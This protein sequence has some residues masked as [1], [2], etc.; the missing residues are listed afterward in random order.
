M[1][2]SSLSI[3]S[4]TASRWRCCTGFETPESW[5]PTPQFF[6]PALFLSFFTC[7]ICSWVE[8][9][10]NDYQTKNTEVHICTVLN[11]HN[12]CFHTLRTI[13][14]INSRWSTR[15]NYQQNHQKNSLW[16]GRSCLPSHQFTDYRP[17]C[18]ILSSQW[19]TRVREWELNIYLK[20]IYWK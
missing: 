14:C 16:N 18:L 2:Y 7:H 19:D 15:K 11:L 3:I 12:S 8:I 10:C 17:A 4:P 20:K 9:K 1:I 13:D 5:P 6:F